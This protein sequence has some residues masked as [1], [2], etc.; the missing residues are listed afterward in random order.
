MLKKEETIKID[1]RMNVLNFIKNKLDNTCV[2]DFYDSKEYELTR[3][4]YIEMAEMIRDI[5]KMKQL[6]EKHNNN[7]N[8]NKYFEER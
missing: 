2:S 5:D 1:C 6:K 3:K 4:E 7:K 8:I